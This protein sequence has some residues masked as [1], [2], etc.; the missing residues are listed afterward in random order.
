MAL[1]LSDIPAMHSRLRDVPHELAAA[2]VL[3]PN[4][5]G[6]AYVVAEAAS[7]DVIAWDGWYFDPDIDESAVPLCDLEWDEWDDMPTK[8]LIRDQSAWARSQME[9]WLIPT[10]SPARAAGRMVSSTEDQETTRQASQ[11]LRRSRVV[12]YLPI[13]DRDIFD[14]A[15]QGAAFF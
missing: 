10:F 4:L 15:R 9:Y 1:T 5:P 13:L 2:V 8:L 6:Y 3:D 11:N 12:A 7:G 14:A